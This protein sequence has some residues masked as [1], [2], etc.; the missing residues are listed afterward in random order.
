MEKNF[1][2]DN[3]EQLL[4]DTTDNFR[5]YPSNRVWHSI[6][7]NL[8]PSR[9]WPSVAVWLLFIFSVIFIGVANKQGPVSKYD[10]INSVNNKE[11][12]K[13]GFQHSPDAGFTE[14]NHWD[15]DKE[16]LLAANKTGVAGNDFSLNTNSRQSAKMPAVTVTGQPIP[17]SGFGKSTGKKNRTIPATANKFTISGGQIT[18]DNNEDVV[19]SKETN[20]NNPL[21]GIENETDNNQPAI[22]VSIT[23]PGVHTTAMDNSEKK[24]ENVNVKVDAN[25]DK[26][27]IEHFAFQNKPLLSK[28]KSRARYQF[29]I[30]PSIGYRAIRKNNSY[31]VAATTSFIT[32]QNTPERQ[33]EQATSHA[34]AVNM[35]LGANVIYS[36]SKLVN[37]KIGVQLNYT[38]Y[39]INA[40]ELKH[41]TMTTL[42]LNDLNTGL[43][44]LSPR[45]TT[46]ANTENVYTTKLNNN[47]YQVSVPIGADIKIAGNHNLKWYAGA[48][49]QPSYIAGGDAYF[50]S[51]DL[52]NYVTDKSLI[53][54]W[55]L[56]GGIETFIS[57]KTKSGIILNAG[58]QF[59]YQ[60][61]S[62]YSKKYSYDEK[63]YNLGLKIGITTR[64]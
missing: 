41:P 2:R 1:Y 59:R 50:I 16:Q 42:L 52:K 48:T 17:E 32:N 28:W 8:H 14:S 13:A 46:L 45:T 64:F 4:R 9:R 24:K 55:N 27:W 11:I 10:E 49:I 6:Y 62:T 25:N 20:S 58:P 40:Y 18:S 12:K 3:F 22:T 30:T 35:E 61:L 31:S 23:A 38:N 5:M 54:K 39:N 21:N 34:P 57:Y 43:P 7:N 37:L 33:F 15:T 47:T 51:S 44:V 56:N 29:Y 36:V 63:L 19:Y 26:E 53:R 60:L